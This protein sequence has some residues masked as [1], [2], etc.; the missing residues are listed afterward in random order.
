MESWER[1]PFVMLE[2]GE[3]IARISIGGVPHFLRLNF[4]CVL[5]ALLVREGAL[6]RPGEP[7]AICLAE[8]DEISCGEYYLSI[9]A[10]GMPVG[11]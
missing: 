1:E 9:R 2:R 10:A 3:C 5:S 8:G 7:L 4:P 6:V 11:K